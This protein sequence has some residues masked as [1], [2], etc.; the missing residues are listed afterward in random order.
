MRNYLLPILLI[1]SSCLESESI[2]T[3]S[4]LYV[5]AGD[6]LV[7]S[8]V[9]DTVHQFDKKGNYKRILYRTP[10]ATE[11]VGGLGWM[12]STNEILVAM[13][14]TPDRVLAISVVDGSNRVA[15]QDAQLGGTIRSVTQLYDSR[16]ILVSEQTAIERFNEL[17]L[18]ETHAAPW[19][20]VVMANVQD[21]KA[22][23]D[24]RWIATSTTQA[25][26]IYN[27]SVTAFA[28]LATAAIPAGTTAAH[29]VA[30][31]ANGKFL[32]SWEGAATDYLS[33]YN[34]DLTLDRHIFGNNQAQLTAP[35]GVAQMANGNYLVADNTLDYVL[36]ISPA[37]QVVKIIGQG[38]L[39]GAYSVLVVPEFSP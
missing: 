32:V 10:L 2:P 31:L 8:S 24:G 27:D 21:I 29:G 28:A 23:Q 17:G 11:T 12:H 14:G 9:T 5:A 25:V 39:D 38:I 19:P 13:E 1:L 4:N 26:R 15:F 37:G 7:S 30:E 16:S 3:T 34:S 6:I 36:E 33:V 22:L 20:S 18:R 35:R